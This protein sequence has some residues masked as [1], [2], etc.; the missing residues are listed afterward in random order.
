[1]LLGAINLYVHFRLDSEDN[2]RKTHRFAGF[3]WVTGGLLFTANAFFRLPYLSIV[4]LVLLV[5]LPFAY[6]YLIYTRQK[7]KDD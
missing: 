3:V 7:R 6:S 2:W 4:I 1:V 5:V